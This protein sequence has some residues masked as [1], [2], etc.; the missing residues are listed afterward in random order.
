MS[1]QPVN[2]DAEL[3]VSQILEGVEQVTAYA[4]K[5]T[6]PDAKLLVWASLL[7]T[8][9]ILLVAERLRELRHEAP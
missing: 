5:S 2:D 8:R 7:Q 3:I 1:A 4:H 6:F 9:A